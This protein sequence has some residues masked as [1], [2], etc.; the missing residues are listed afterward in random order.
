MHTVMLKAEY[1]NFFVTQHKDIQIEFFNRKMD[2]HVSIIV[3]K[4]VGSAV[5]VRSVGRA[6]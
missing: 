5:H 3:R 2:S 1:T 4:L 6:C